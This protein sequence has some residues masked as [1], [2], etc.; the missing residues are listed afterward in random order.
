MKLI[1]YFVV[2]V[3]FHPG[4]DD[5]RVCN[6]GPERHFLASTGHAP[7]DKQLTEDEA[8]AMLE[9]HG[10]PK[11]SIRRILEKAESSSRARRSRLER[12]WEQGR[13]RRELASSNCETLQ[14]RDSQ[15]GSSALENRAG[16]PESCN[17]SRLASHK[18]A[19]R[20]V[21][22][23]EA[24]QPYRFSA[25]HN[26]A[27]TPRR[28]PADAEG[29]VCDMSEQQAAA[30]LRE[31]GFSQGMIDRYLQD[32]CIVSQARRV[33]VERY[34]AERGQGWTRDQGKHDARSR[35]AAAAVKKLSHSCTPSGPESS[36]LKAAGEGFLR[37]ESHDTQ[38]REGASH[39]SPTP[40][41]SRSR[42]HRVVVI[43]HGRQMPSSYSSSSHS[44]N[45]ECLTA[46]S[47]PSRPTGPGSPCRQRA[48]DPAPQPR[49][50]GAATAE[51][52][53]TLQR[54]KDRLRAEREAALRELRE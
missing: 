40:G 2:L 48:H 1:M 23:A 37:H 21:Q 28:V 35:G 36:R 5:V 45:Q 44:D 33:R 12:F 54:E 52:S 39:S 25:E 47:T 6:A 24:V 4:C 9:E 34:N 30:L 43:Q 17:S 10:F 8:V 14:P 31:C 22:V 15:P 29:D 51:K 13:R 16:R 20:H 53:S 26:S 11:E 46:Q 19:R 42:R 50:S 32:G 38:R 49:S 18:N 3:S 7:P 41:E 27:S